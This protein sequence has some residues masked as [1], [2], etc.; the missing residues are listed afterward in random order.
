MQPHHVISA[1][2]SA[3]PLDGMS[4]LD[5][6]SDDAKDWLKYALDPFHDYQLNSFNGYP[7]VSTEPTVVVKVRQAIEISAP[8]DLPADTN[9]DCHVFLSPI[10]WN[11]GDPERGPAAD[12]TGVCGVFRAS[13]MGYPSGGADPYS[14]SGTYVQ[15]G[16]GSS[17]AQPTAARMDGLVVN[18]VPSTGGISGNTTFTPFNCPDNDAQVNPGY[19]SQNIVLDKYLDYERQDLGAY[20]LCYS[21]FEVV[22]T[23]AD[24]YK[25][26]ACT[27][28]EYGNSFEV[29]S[30]NNPDLTDATSGSTANIPC[31]W[32]RCP[33]NTVAEAK[34]MPGAHTWAARDGC[35]NTAKFQTDNPFQ[36]ATQRPWLIAQNDRKNA[37]YF[38]DTSPGGNGTAEAG[39]F[40]S[41]ALSPLQSAGNKGAHMSRMSSTG[42][43]FTGLSPQTTLFVT[44]RVGIERLPAANKPNFLALATPSATYDP[45]AL[46]LYNLIASK[47]PPG[48]PQGYNDA[49]KWFRMISAAARKVL[50]HAFPLVGAAQLMLTSMGHPE[51]AAGV[52]VAGQYL[53]GKSKKQPKAPPQT[54]TKSKSKLGNMGSSGRLARKKAVQNFSKP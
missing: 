27:V 36:T 24:I 21:G 33:P 52:G 15:P 29:A 37:G 20:R 38:E 51:L 47:L 34:I 13:A 6:I 44:W 17:G 43:Y 2:K 10:D 49:G 14:G 11:A 3:D 35:Y 50:P 39:S 46:V 26:G 30:A 1:T 5:Q 9:W 18:S 23:T 28:Y 4:D 41:L 32:F 25:Q 22:N 42:A 40:G 7:D 12:G 54:T 53:Q 48:V 31:N 45:S 16:P 19:E 8:S